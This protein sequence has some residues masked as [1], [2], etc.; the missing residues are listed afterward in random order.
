MSDTKRNNHGA[1]T[2]EQQCAIADTRHV[3]VSPPPLAKVMVMMTTEGNSLVA[4]SP[5][6]PAI[7]PSL[8]EKIVCNR[9]GGFFFVVGSESI[10]ANPPDLEEKFG[11]I[12][13]AELGM[14]LHP[15]DKGYGDFLDHRFVHKSGV[16]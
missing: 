7:E 3:A 6:S 5:A 11:N 4:H 16:Q 8:D 12:T 13:Y 10:E 1:F 2:R 14:T 15:I 9:L